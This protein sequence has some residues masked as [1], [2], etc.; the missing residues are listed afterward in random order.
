MVAR[1]DRIRKLDTMSVRES[2]D[3][4]SEWGVKKQVLGN[5]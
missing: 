4:D 2:S 3:L 1:P 5:S